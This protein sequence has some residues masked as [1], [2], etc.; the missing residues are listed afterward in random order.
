MPTHL[1]SPMSLSTMRG[2]LAAF[3]LA[4]LVV[5]AIAVLAALGQPVPDVLS[6]VV[7]VSVSAAA[8]AAVPR[9]GAPAAAPTP[10]SA[11]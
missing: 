5:T 4:A 11:P 8:G 10:V 6:T 2:D 7:L 3:A 9:T 1:E